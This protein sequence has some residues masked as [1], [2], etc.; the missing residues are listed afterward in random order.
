MIYK[1][2]SFVYTDKKSNCLVP[3][4]Y[5]KLFTVYPCA[6]SVLCYLVLIPARQAAKPY[7]KGAAGGIS[8]LP[9]SI[10]SGGSDVGARA[11]EALSKEWYCM[12]T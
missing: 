8:Q 10:C 3:F 4:P 11:R 6:A 12:Y 2:K 1:I 7:I 9:P 5:F